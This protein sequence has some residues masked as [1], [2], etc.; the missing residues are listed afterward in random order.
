MNVVSMPLLAAPSGC[1]Q[2]PTI[3]EANAPCGYGKSP[4][5]IWAPR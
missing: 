4:V 3:S 1:S 5:L 2:W